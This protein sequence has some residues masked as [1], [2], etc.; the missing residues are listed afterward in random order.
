MA[1]CKGSRT[2]RTALAVLCLLGTGLAAVHAQMAGGSSGM[3]SMGGTASGT[4]A[5]TGPGGSD[6][7]R[8]WDEAVSRTGMSQEQRS[9]LASELRKTAGA[10]SDNWGSLEGLRER[11]ATAIGDARKTAR[12]RVDLA[13]AERDLIVMTTQ[14]LLRDFLNDEQVE[15]VMSAA[16][17]GVSRSHSEEAHPMAMGMGADGSMQTMSGFQELEME[18]ARTAL[19]INERSQAVSVGELITLLGGTSPMSK[20]V[21]QGGTAP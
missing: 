13:E 20:P 15:L 4:S 6:L 11:E 7:A 16:F 12:R 19:E 9:R 2:A 21:D 1:T 3:V 5:S 18:L 10:L 8:L 14:T 17:H